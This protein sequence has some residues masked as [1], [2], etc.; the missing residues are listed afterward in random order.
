MDSN[1]VT[2]SELISGMLAEARRLGMSESTI[3]RDWEPKANSVVMFY[4]KRG[5]CVY[6]SEVTEEYL[7][8]YEK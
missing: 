1:T 8:H 7:N 2:I 5:L 3:W 6:S 4:R